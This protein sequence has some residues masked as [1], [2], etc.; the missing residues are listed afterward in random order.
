MNRY[1]ETD[2]QTDTDTKNHKSWT[3]VSNVR[4]ERTGV[5]KCQ[6]VCLSISLILM[7]PPTPNIRQGPILQNYLYKLKVEIFLSFI[8]LFNIYSRFSK[9][10]ESK[11]TQKISIVNFVILE[12][13]SQLKYMS[14][15][16]NVVLTAR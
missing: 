6:S 14:C 8:D 10:L 7:F 15:L 5:K 9:W 12:I 11:S 1:I 3:E 13:F 4:V 16:W 2:R